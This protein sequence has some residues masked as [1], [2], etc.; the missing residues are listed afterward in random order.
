MDRAVSGKNL[1]ATLSLSDKGI[2]Q[3]SY[4]MIY[5]RDSRTVSDV[6]SRKLCERTSSDAH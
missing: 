3:S 4:G 5:P 1:P 2:H 6:W